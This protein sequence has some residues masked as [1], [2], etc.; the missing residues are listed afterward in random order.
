MKIMQSHR[1]L[2]VDD[3]AAI[4]DYFREILLGH[5]SRNPS[6]DATEALLFDE[7]KAARPATAELLIDSA[8]QG[9]KALQKVEKALAEARPTPCRL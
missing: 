9:R 5:Q 1:I 6:L 8:F 2:I 7:E 4:H 3:N